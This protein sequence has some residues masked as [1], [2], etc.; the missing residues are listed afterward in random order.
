M[1][2]IRLPVAVAGTLAGAVAVT[3]VLAAAAQANPRLER[4]LVA[5]TNVDRASN[6]LSALVENEPLIG[7]ARE[8][9]EDM[10]ARNYFGH[11]IPPDGTL[12][13]ALMDA[14]AIAYRAA[15]ENLA[16]NNAGESASVQR[17]QSDFM[18]S[19]SHRANILEARFDEIGVG[20]IPGP[21]KTVFTVLFLGSS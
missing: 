17:A 21:T 13:F 14:R 15:G 11:E 18:N 10:Q 8:R 19:P 6:G 2:M 12:V 20:A 7:L 9:S 3:T 1:V 5:L 16:A 4:D